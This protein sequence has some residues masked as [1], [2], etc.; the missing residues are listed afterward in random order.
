MP[1][2]EIVAGAISG[3][4]SLVKTGYDIWANSRDFDYQKSLQQDIFNRED[5][6]I[7]RRV[8]DLKAAGLNPNLAA[9][10]AAG[11]G[12]VV[13]RSNTPSLSGNSIGTALDMATHVQQ[14]RN[15]R[16]ENQILQN[17][18][19]KQ[20]YDNYAQYMSNLYNEAELYSYLGLNPRVYFNQ[21]GLPRI[22]IDHKEVPVEV[23]PLG[24]QLRYQWQNNKNSADLLQ[25]DVN[26]YNAKQ[27]ESMIGTAARSIGGLAGGIGSAYKNFNYM[28]PNYNT[29]HNSSNIK[30]NW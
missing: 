14:L 22:K 25:K 2:G 26:W 12:A 7:Q 27:I 1:I 30:N 16:E 8:A 15:L 9:G 3:I 21:N 4:G 23:S 6:A 17:Q 5:T 11:A 18:K 29:Y 10:S 20:S 28:P 19:Q 13:G 24:F